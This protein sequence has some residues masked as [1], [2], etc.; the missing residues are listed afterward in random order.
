M[1]VPEAAGV[2]DAALHGLPGDG[3]VPA[4]EIWRQRIHRAFARLEITG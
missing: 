3:E 4:Y 1:S 2:T